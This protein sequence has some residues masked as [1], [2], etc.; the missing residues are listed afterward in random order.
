MVRLEKKIPVTVNGDA[1]TLL[2]TST[3]LSRTRIKR[4]MTRGAVWLTRSGH[5]R[6]L[7]RATAQVRSGDELAIYYDE[8]ILDASPPEPVCIADETQYSV[9]IKPAGVMSSGTRF[10][11]HSA[12]NRL[13]EKLWDRPVYLV[14]R[15]D[16]YAFGL[17]VLAHTRTAAA[18]LS[19]QF[20]AREVHKQYLAVVSGIVAAEQTIDTSLDDKPAVTRVRPLAANDERSLVEVIIETGRKHQIRRH[21]AALG[22]AVIGDRQYGEST[23]G[24]L[25]LASCELGFRSPANGES[26]SY[27][28]PTTWHPDLDPVAPTPS[29]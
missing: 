7:R 18:D 27:R 1:L 8:K 10:G 17:I 25:Q 20:R 14:H 26:V 28:L 24:E 9:W 3:N 16:Q 29:A 6:R 23:S 12:I 13:V 2:A 21:L 15:L 11:D 4:A 5:H 22:H 19:K